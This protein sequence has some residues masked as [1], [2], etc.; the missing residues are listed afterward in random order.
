M[1]DS[2]TSIGIQVAEILSRTIDTIYV[3]IPVLLAYDALLC[4]EKEV[5]Y[6]WWSPKAERKLSRLLY[7]YNRYMSIIWNTLTLG[8]LGN[9]SD[10]RHVFVFADVLAMLGPAAFTTLRVYAI[11]ERNK[12]LTGVVL[13]LSLGPFI[14]NACTLYQNVTIN[15]PQP[16]VACTIWPKLITKFGRLTVIARTCLILADLLAIIITWRHTHTA[17]RTSSDNPQR[18]SMEQILWDNGN[19]YFCTLVSLNIANMVLVTLSLTTQSLPNDAF[20]VINFI[21]PISSILNS[22]FLLA[23]YETNAYLEKGGTSAATTVSTLDFGG[24]NRA[25]RSELPGYLSSLAGPIHSIP[26]DDAG[27]FDSEPA[28]CETEMGAEAEARADAET[29]ESRAS[30]GA[31]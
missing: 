16:S 6:V 28:S 10:T 9:T 24:A 27:L 1:S 30:G 25:G 14:V 8:L 13:L 22:R 19:I 4:M 3:V 17:R 7:I 15:Y 20:Y 29:E 26:D 31:V 18:S 5:Q 11:S 23:L 21:D 12:V 2:A